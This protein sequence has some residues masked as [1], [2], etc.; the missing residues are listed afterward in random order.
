[1]EYIVISTVIAKYTDAAK[2]CKDVTDK[3]NNGFDLYGDL[4]T[5]YVPMVGHGGVNAGGHV[6]YSQA[7]VKK[8]K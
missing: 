1:M 6:N 5:Y 4:N 8:D 2:F 7:M 3:L